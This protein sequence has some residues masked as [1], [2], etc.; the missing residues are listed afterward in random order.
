MPSTVM[1]ACCLINLYAADDLTSLLT[2]IGGEF[3]VPEI[4]IAETLYV[5][6]E[7]QA[8]ESGTTQRQ[9]DLSAA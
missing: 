8:T 5:I 2:A 7:D 9:I 6:E 3:Y 1:D 4:V